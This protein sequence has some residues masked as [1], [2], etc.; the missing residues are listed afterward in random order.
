MIILWNFLDKFEIIAFAET[1]SA[2]KLALN[3]FS[4][5]AYSPAKN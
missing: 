5:L 3:N 4:L 1:F 2:V